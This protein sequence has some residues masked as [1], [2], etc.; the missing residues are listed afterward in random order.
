[1]GIRD[2]LPSSRFTTVVGSIALAA[3][4]VWGAY[5]LTHL[6]AP[7]PQTLSVDTQLVQDTDWKTAL[8]DIQSQNPSNKAPQ[9]PSPDKVNTLLSAATSDNLTDTVARTLF[10][11]LSNAKA[12]GLGD[13]IPTQ[14]ELIA[15]A[16]S[17][18]RQKPAAKVYTNVD[19]ALADNTQGAMKAYGNAFMSA[20][21]AHP[22]ASYVATVYAIGTTTDNGDPSRLKSLASIGQDYGALAKDISKVAVPSSLLPI[23]LQILNNMERMAELYPDMQK[24]YTD[25]LR[26]LASFQL[27]D[28]LT[29]ETLRLFI[30]VAQQFS[31][32]GILFSK[33]DPGHAWSALVP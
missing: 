13:D 12:Q 29:Q 2:I 17:Q 31:Q 6:P 26:A 9:P 30:N 8:E 21:E 22:N 14:D 15:Q 16:A 19:I 10:I 25:P 18:I 33:D 3:L 28:A 11:N 27:Y 1:M 7:Q 32:D 5:T 23:H 4:L 24:I 20:V